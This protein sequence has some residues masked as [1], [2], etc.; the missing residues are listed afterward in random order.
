MRKLF[1]ILLLLGGFSGALLEAQN[2][3]VN[4]FF[5]TADFTAWSKTADTTMGTVTGGANLGMEWYCVR[6]SPG[7]PTENGCFYQD[8]ALKAG[9]T[10]DFSMNIGA[11]Y[12]CAG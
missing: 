11:I 8:V 1:L 12:I 7:T 10:Y 2:T 4:P 3:V 9:E 5:S 6:K